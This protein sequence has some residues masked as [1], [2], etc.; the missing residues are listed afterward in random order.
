MNS[1]EIINNL[2][3]GVK[4]SYSENDL[5]ISIYNYVI[6]T[7]PEIVVELGTLHGYSAICIGLA[8]RDSGF[9]KLTCYDLWEDY[10]FTHT[11]MNS[12]METIRSHGLDDIISLNKSSAF[13]WCEKVEKFDLLHVDISND[14]EKIK[15]IFNLLSSRVREGSEILFEGGTRERDENSWIN[16]FGFTPIESI[17]E[18]TG[19][20]VLDERWPGLSLISIRNK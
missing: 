2:Y 8:L 4:S 10:E 5:G 18:E 16:T 11:A 20:H 7:K 6:S 19:Y 3:K 15:K 1:L 17:K 9:G 12:T 14:G 13:R